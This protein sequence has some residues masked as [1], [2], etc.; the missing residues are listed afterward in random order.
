[1][2]FRLFAQ[3]LRFVLLLALLSSFESRAEP[4]NAA[5]KTAVAPKT[6]LA[7]PLAPPDATEKMIAKTL[8]EI[9]SNDHYLQHPLDKEIS[10]KFYTQYLN[11][12][13]GY[14]L[15]FLQSDLDEFEPYRTKLDTLT[16]KDGDTSL[17]R[18]V[19]NRFMERFEQR[20]TYT[21]NLILTGQFDFSGHER[22]TPDRRKTNAPVTMDE[23]RRSGVRN[24]AISISTKNSRPKTFSS[25]APSAPTPKA[26]P[27]FF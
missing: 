14:H 13:D 9:F 1:M 15:H 19:F 24:S 8:G 25:P 5:A 7:T 11:A 16:L 4:T 3:S 22:Y 27:A 12:L 26:R 17:A 10:A 21:T 23:L 20:I 6:G 18:L 2:K